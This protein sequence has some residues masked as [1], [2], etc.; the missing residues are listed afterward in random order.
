MSYRAA[1]GL[2]KALIRDISRRKN[3]P[4]WMLD[5]RLKCLEMYHQIDAPSWGPD[6]S[7]LDITHIS[8][9]VQPDSK[10]VSSWEKVPV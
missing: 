10:M 1:D 7:G 9:Y 2:N 4:E 8:N 5:F 3:E 6:L